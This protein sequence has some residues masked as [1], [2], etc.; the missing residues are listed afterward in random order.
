M[1]FIHYS[2]KHIHHIHSVQQDNLLGFKPRGLW[3]TT[4]EGDNWKAW[5]ESENFSV[6]NLTHATQ[7]T[8]KRLA[9]VLRL[10]G[11]KAIDTFTDRYGMAGHN[12]YRMQID[13]IHVA[14]DYGA[15]VIAPYCWR[16]RNTIHTF[17]YYP[18]DCASGCVWDAAVIGGLMPIRMP[19]APPSG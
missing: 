6:G 16:R 9:K 3:F 10:S 8:F 17:W 12:G 14:N 19:S 2:N 7:I 13:W 18:W 15:I 4:T 1:K 5:C 11:M